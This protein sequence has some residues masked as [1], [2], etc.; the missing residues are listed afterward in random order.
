MPL[1]AITHRDLALLA[2]ADKPFNCAGWIFELKYDGFRCLAKVRGGKAA[3]LTRKG[4]DVAAA[5]PEITDELSRLP[6]CALDGELVVLDENGLPEFD[7]L[8]ARSRKVSAASIAAGAKERPA[9]LFAFDLLILDGRDLRSKPLR[10]RKAALQSLL[11]RSARVRYLEHIA[12][13]G[14]GLYAAA[15]KLGMEGIVAKDGAAPYRSGRSRDWLKIKT[16]LG[17]RVTEERGD[18]WYDAKN[19]DK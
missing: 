17:K 11:R 18:A 13:E 12:D 4:N 16:A 1:S 15:K 14:E 7:A 5:F 3:L 10:D 9:V 8:A 6:D 2:S 19:P